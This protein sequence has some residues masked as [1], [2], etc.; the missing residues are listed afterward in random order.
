MHTQSSSEV[1]EIELKWFLLLIRSKGAHNK[2][3][4]MDT[5]KQA[6]D[7]HKRSCLLILTFIETKRLSIFIFV[8]YALSSSSFDVICICDALLSFFLY[9]Q[10]HP[11]SKGIYHYSKYQ[12]VHFNLFRYMI[13]IV[14]IAF[15]AFYLR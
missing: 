10:M 1:L 2:K 5:K 14:G 4:Q 8:A 9:P 11:S 15:F 12:N 3:G 13:I 6:K 7:M